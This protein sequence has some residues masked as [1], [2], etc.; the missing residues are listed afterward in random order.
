M[1]MK[2]RRQANQNHE[3]PKAR[4]A[5]SGKQVEG[6][7]LVWGFVFCLFVLRQCLFY[8]APAVLELTMQ[9]RLASNSQ[10]SLPLPLST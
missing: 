7:A 5:G 1:R 9:T 6:L 4:V 3:I 2:I 8:V 10:R